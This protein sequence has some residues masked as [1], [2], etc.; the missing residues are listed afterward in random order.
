MKWTNGFLVCALVLFPITAWAGAAEVLSPLEKLPPA[1]R[2][3]RL[4]EGA[5]KEGEIMIYSSSGLEEIRALVK[6]FGKKYPFLQVRYNK[7]G[8]S[9]LFTV[10]QMEFVGKKYLADVYWAGYSTIGPMLRE[11]GMLARHLSPERAAV[12]E[13]YKDREGYWTAT[14][15]SMAIFAYHAK[16]VPQ[17]KVPKDYWDLLDPFWKGKI[18]IDSSPGRFTHLLVEKYGWEKA[19]DFHRKL[20]AQ[21]PRIHRGRT[22]R[23]QL[24][25]AGEALG[26][27]D[28]N[29]DNIIGM[30]KENAPL[31]FAVMEPTLLSLTSVAVPQTPAHPH[32]AALFYDYILS[33][34][35]QEA[36][37]VEDNIPIRDDVEIKSPEL[38]KRYRDGRAQKKFIIQSPGTYDPAAEE[39][40]D[41]LYV[42]TLLKKG[43]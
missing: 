13:E 42:D 2:Q 40:N 3:R 16:K 32:A 5:R 19:A 9:Q 15:I 25:L 1:E 12:A 43:R 18:S 14:R 37:A 4:I 41:K 23:V 35:G 7:K 22:A 34:E 36:L 30:Q 28:I 20:A 11:K 27:L 10:A 29:A 17:D 26:A 24:I 6:A 39:K 38:A 33:K 31:D 21:D 8:G